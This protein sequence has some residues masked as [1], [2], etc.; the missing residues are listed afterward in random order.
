MQG[1]RLLFQISHWLVRIEAKEA[2]AT[3]LIIATAENWMWASYPK[4]ASG[5]G[6]GISQL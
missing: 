4:Q 5:F 2:C 3:G 6:Y 1:G